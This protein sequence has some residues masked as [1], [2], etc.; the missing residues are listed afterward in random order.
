ML[1]LKVCLKFAFNL[2]LKYCCLCKRLLSVCLIGG[3]RGGWLPKNRLHQCY[4][5]AMCKMFSIRKF[6]CH[7]HCQ[8]VGAR[9]SFVVFLTQAFG[10]LGHG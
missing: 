3:M 5:P 10:R 2:C 1:S 9:L 4:L 7:Y 8:F 6:C